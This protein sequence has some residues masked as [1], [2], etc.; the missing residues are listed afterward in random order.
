MNFTEALVVSRIQQAKS[1]QLAVVDVDGSY[2]YRKQQLVAQT[3]VQVAP[4]PPPP[5][6]LTGWES[7]SDSTID[8]ISPRVP[9][10]TSGES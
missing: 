7:V 1:E 3:G 6:P 5:P 4:L 8:T 10:V 2:L 9:T